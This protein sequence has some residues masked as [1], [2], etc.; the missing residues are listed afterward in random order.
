MVNSSHYQTNVNWNLF[1]F[2]I[3]TKHRTSNILFQRSKQNLYVHYLY[4]VLPIVFGEFFKNMKYELRNM[5]K[6]KNRY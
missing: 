6:I 3:I 5:K 1:F 2:F 4:S